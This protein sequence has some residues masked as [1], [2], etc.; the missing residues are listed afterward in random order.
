MR[1]APT[2]KRYKMHKFQHFYFW[3]L[4][5][6]LYVFWIFFTDYKKYFSRKIGA[7][8]LKKMDPKDHIEFWAVKAYHAA[9]FVVVPI[10]FSAGSIG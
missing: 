7:V 2:Q 9:V 6:L 4:Y 8:P 10:I 3:F 1:M 5:M